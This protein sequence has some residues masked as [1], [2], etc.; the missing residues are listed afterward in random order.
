MKQVPSEKQRLADADPIVTYLVRT[1]NLSALGFALLSCTVLVI[2]T[3]LVAY[4]S[5]TLW[6]PPS[7]SQKGLMQD[8][9]PWI[10]ILFIN[11][12][13][14]GYYLWSSQAIGRVLQKLENSD[15]V[16]IELSEIRQVVSRFY[17][18]R[19]RQPLALSSAV[20][21]SALVFFTR[22]QLKNSWTSSAPL[23][24]AAT[25][26]ATFIVVYAGSVLVLNLIANIQ[27]LH[28]ILKRKPLHI[29]PLHPD[30]CGGLQ[31]LSDYALKAAYLAAALGVWVGVI[32][33]QFIQQTTQPPWFVHLSIPLHL[34]LSV[35]C[36]YGP[37]LAAHRG[38]KKA[39]ADLLH[40]IAQQFQID[41]ADIHSCLS[42]DAET[43]KKGAEKIQQLRAF[44]ATTDE[45]P[46]WPFN[47]TVFR[48]YL[49]IA[50]T[51]LLTL[52]TGLLRGLISSWLGLPD[53]LRQ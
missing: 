7:Q 33:Y 5:A 3:L 18:Q 43:L 19:W 6:L 27:I 41:Y 26:I 40:Q 38:M 24:I 20:L 23:P 39:K 25:T 46:V 48:Q 47:T 37:L 35:V 10:A 45:F 11:P 16:N 31:P 4:L 44:Y 49:L 36:F 9:I 22:T 42:E 28:T 12:V 2:L 14:L 15:V 34:C 8:G 51:P 30:R 50:S 53:S 52:L 32:E 13:V 21:F 1:F 29:S 17:R